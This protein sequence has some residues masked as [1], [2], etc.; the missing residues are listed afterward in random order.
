M[1]NVVDATDFKSWYTRKVTTWDDS[2]CL[3][4]YEE[5]FYNEKKRFWPQSN[6]GIDT[7]VGVGVTLYP[8]RRLV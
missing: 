2:A 1:K 5:T 3:R 4:G 6:G 7:R 8:S